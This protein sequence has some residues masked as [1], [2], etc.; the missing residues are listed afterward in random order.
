MSGVVGVGGGGVIS[1]DVSRSMSDGGI[2]ASA[3]SEL[4]CDGHGGVAASDH[5]SPLLSRLP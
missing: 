3:H 2:A 4:S 1:S 5:R